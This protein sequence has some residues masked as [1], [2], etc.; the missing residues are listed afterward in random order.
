MTSR[1]PRRITLRTQLTALYAIVFMLAA[2]ALLALTLALVST[3]LDRAAAVNSPAQQQYRA[4]LEA[5]LKQA[6]QEATNAKPDADVQKRRAKIKQLLLQANA[7][8]GDTIRADTLNTVLGASLL[9][10]VVLVPASGLGGWL[11]AGRALRPVGAITEAARRAS[12][13]QLHERLAL[14]GPRDE[15]TDLAD[16]FDNMLDRLEHAFDTQ[17]RFVANASHELRTPLA[18]ARTAIEVTLAKPRRTTEHLEQMAADVHGAVNRAEHLVEGLLT[19]TRSQHLAHATEP[20]DLATA[21]RTPWT[22]K[23]AKSTRGPSPCTPASNPP[24]PPGTAPC[25]TAWSATWSTM[26]SGTTNPAAG[27]PC[28]LTTTAGT[29]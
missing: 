1:A 26:R 29:P 2:S 13:T 12:E 28:T 20:T 21:A 19:L 23:P 11:L 27:S 24:R 4:D 18:V 6:D 22:W 7:V 8:S 10:I 5:A 16:T 3:S 25:S 14:R 9:A 17:R 15:I